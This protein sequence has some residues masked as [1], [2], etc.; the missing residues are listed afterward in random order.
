MAYTIPNSCFGCGSCQPQCPTGAIQLDDEQ[1]WIE[2]DLCNSCKGYYPEPQCV[3]GCPI[4]SP[5]PLKAKKGRYKTDTR[6]ATS[7]DLFVNGKNTHF[8]SSMVIWEACKVLTSATIL[9]WEIDH[10][11]KLYYQQSVK[12]GQGTITFR[13]T[14][15]LESNSP[16]TLD[17]I[18]AK[19]AIE[20]IDIR[21]ACLHLIYAAYA[22]TLDK[23]WEQ[24]FV[25][26]DRQI[27]KYLGLD[28]RTD[29]SKAAKLTV[30]KDIAQ[31]P[32][33]ITTSID[34]PQQG[35]VKGFCLEESHLWH[36]LEIKHY[37]QEDSQGYKHLVGLTFR[38]RAGIW[39]EYF[40]NKQDYKKRTA[41]YQYGTLPKFILN[42]VATVWQQH[43]GTVRMMLWLLFKTKMR[44]QQCLKVS[45]L[46]Y[47]AY[48]KE[49]VN[50]A[51]S[52]REVRKRLVQTFESDLEVLNHYGLK[53]IFDSVTYTPEIQPLWAKLAVL[54][55]DA[56][57]ALDFWIDDGSRDQRLT[58]SGPRGKW[59]LLM[60]ARFLGFNLPAE[61]EQQLAKFEAKKQRI[62][63]K[64]SKSKTTTGLSAQQIL[65]ARKRRGMT[66]RGLAE[67][68][69]KSQSWIRDLEKGRLSAKPEDQALLRKVLGLG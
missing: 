11:G 44:K 10:E 2:P 20:S 13:L 67:M 7:P 1:Y 24:E 25:I 69:G 23:P 66:Q 21:S 3:T 4:S 54:P 46:M 63:S 22:T 59:N 26:D 39:A 8:A 60:E 45:T 31:Q 30:I 52:Q 12:Q 41:F 57:A 65:S 51:S 49:K 9:P 15:N 55:D 38:V 34:W 68:T 29:L 19:K 50:Q 32:C 53:P 33:K 64:R 62:M 27:E 14:N 6:L 61:W 58:D 28:K 16:K 37:F 36:L 35:K 18:A 56:D 48:G 43:K 42:T 40:L 17:Y 5:V 47:I